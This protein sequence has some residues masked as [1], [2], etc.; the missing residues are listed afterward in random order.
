[1]IVW[2]LA[3][4]LLYKVEQRLLGAEQTSPAFKG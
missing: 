3:F 4:L 1:M 2:K